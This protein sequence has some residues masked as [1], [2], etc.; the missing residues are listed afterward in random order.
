MPEAHPISITGPDNQT[1][2]KLLLPGGGTE[3]GT[4]AR[5]SQF[6][7]GLTK[8][9]VPNNNRKTWHLIVF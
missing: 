1:V 2:R 6:L 9:P 4:P 8:I 5:G 3:E 7:I